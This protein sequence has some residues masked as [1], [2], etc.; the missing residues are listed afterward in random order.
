MHDTAALEQA[1]VATTFVISEAF[2]QAATVQAK[3]LGTSPRVVLA[4]HPIQ[5]RTDDEM[6]ALA[7]GLVQELVTALTT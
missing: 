1:G 6:N 2:S 7:D 5:D 4:A 3:A